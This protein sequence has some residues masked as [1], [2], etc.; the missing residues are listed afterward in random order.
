MVMDFRGEIGPVVAW[1]D[2]RLRGGATMGSKT[3]DAA[4]LEGSSNGIAILGAVDNAVGPLKCRRLVCRRDI[5]C[6][7]DDFP[8]ITSLVTVGQ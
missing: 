6:V 2:Y 1:R 4:T 3:V 7:H 8:P 5:L